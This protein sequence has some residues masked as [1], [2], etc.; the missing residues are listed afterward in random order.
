MNKLKRLFPSS[1]RQ[2]FERHVKQFKPDVVLCTHYL[3]LELLGHRHA[4]QRM[5][6]KPLDGERHHRF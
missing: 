5:G 1:S 3:P 6:H 4:E 2:K